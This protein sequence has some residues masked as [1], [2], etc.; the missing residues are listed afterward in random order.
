M[1]IA[2][3]FRVDG[4]GFGFVLP[5]EELTSSANFSPSIRTSL[6]LILLGGSKKG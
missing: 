4:H 6:R 5:D 3:C 2:F 1:K